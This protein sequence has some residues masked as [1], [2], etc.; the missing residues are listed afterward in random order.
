MDVSAYE[1]CTVFMNREIGYISLVI[2]YHDQFVTESDMTMIRIKDI[3]FYYLNTIYVAGTK[4]KSGTCAFVYSLLKTH[5]GKTGFLPIVGF[6]TL[7][8]PQCVQKRGQIN[9]MPI[10][11]PN[12]TK[13]VFW[14][15]G[16]IIN[17]LVHKTSISQTL[18]ASINSCIY[19]QDFHAAIYEKYHGREYNATNVFLNPVVT[20][21]TI[22]KIDHVRQ[23][24]LS[25]A[26]IAWY[27]TSINK[28]VI[29]DFSTHQHPATSVILQ[30]WVLEK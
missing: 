14:S 25:I 12:F 26:N 11:K 27:K 13:Y 21:I 24:G 8:H 9:S 30:L 29:P 28:P 17:L 19:W 6:C 15:L 2:Q 16:Q 1:D 10:P 7:L 22:M 5:E 3:V 4:R 18:D 20:G 23:L